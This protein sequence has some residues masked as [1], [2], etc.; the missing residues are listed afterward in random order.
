MNKTEKGG[1]NV[2]PTSPAKG[3]GN[4]KVEK[5]RLG[6]PSRD[7]KREKRRSA[8]IFFILRTK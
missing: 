4:M 1:K 6:F 8:L 2:I 5:M 7:Q 3:M